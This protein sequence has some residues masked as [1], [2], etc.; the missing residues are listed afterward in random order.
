MGL[1]SIHKLCRQDFANFLP[2]PPSVGINLCS[3][4]GIW[5]T[6]LP[7]ACLRILWMPPKINAVTEVLKAILYK[8]WWGF[9]IFRL[10]LSIF[11]KKN[12]INKEK[13]QKRDTVKS[14]IKACFKL[15]LCDFTEFLQNKALFVLNRNTVCIHDERDR[16]RERER[17]NWSP[18]FFLWSLAVLFLIAYR[19]TSI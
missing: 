6:P 10:I 5:Q 15:K 7:L 14:W 4:I 2:P 17:E 16:E 8:K 13:K 9:E 1:G 18:V 3:S 19:Q 12:I 11:S